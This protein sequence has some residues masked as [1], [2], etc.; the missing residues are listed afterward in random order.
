MT[1][2]EGLLLAIKH[3][4]QLQPLNSEVLDNKP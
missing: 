2:G 4:L 3:D 1:S